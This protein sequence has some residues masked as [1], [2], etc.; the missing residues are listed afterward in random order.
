MSKRMIEFLPWVIMYK[1]YTPVFKIY[2]SKIVCPP[3]P[4]KYFWAENNKRNRIMVRINF[5]VT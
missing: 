4:D 5:I 2:L 3:R 1:Y